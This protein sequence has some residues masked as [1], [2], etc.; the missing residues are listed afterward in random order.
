MVRLL[1]L[2]PVLIPIARTLLRNPKVRSLLHLKPI[3]QS[4]RGSKRV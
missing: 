3:P 1:R 2:L 4:G